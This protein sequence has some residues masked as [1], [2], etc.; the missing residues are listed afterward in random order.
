MA[1]RMNARTRLVRAKAELDAIVLEALRIVG[2]SVPGST[3]DVLARNVILRAK[4]ALRMLNEN[5]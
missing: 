4:Y 5:D 3:T 2:E 1:R